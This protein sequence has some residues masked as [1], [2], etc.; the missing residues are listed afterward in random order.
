MLRSKQI[1][2]HGL[3]RQILSNVLILGVVKHTRR[4]LSRGGEWPDDL[5]P[6]VSFPSDEGKEAFSDKVGRARC[7]CSRRKE[8][9]TV[10]SELAI[11]SPRKWSRS[12]W[13]GNSHVSLAE[14]AGIHRNKHPFRFRCRPKPNLCN[15]SDCHIGPRMVFRGT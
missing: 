12:R 13:I 15:G 6:N 10:T 4:P 14:S 9:W 7:A 11:H 8:V 2:P 1:H 5:S 3:R